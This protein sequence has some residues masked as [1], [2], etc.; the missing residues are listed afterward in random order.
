MGAITN[1]LLSK[2][3]GVARYFGVTVGDS[4]NEIEIIDSITGLNAIIKDFRCST[5][6]ND[7]NLTL[8]PQTA[9]AA[10][11]ATIA[12]NGDTILKCIAFSGTNI[13]P[14]ELPSSLEVLHDYKEGTDIEFH[15]HWYP[16]NT[17]VANV[18]WQL[19]YSWFNKN[20]AAAAGATAFVISAA[21]GV[22][23]QEQTAV[24]TLSGTGKLMGSRLVFSLF[25]DATDAADTY[26][27][28][29]AVTDMGLHYQR[30]SLGS[31]TQGAK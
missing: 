6:Y 3:S 27:F 11:P 4:T 17:T 29:A 10:I 18:K 2:A 21:S 8:V 19:R 26:A 23:W 20:G 13:T 14:D 5:A 31:R 24:I 30:D 22:A 1:I 16:I 9:G 15:V 28:N 25:R 12:F 7:I